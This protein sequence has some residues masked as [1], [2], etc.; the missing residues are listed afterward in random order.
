MPFGE[1]GLDSRAALTVGKH[2]LECAGASRRRRR[3]M[4]FI[5]GLRV[6]GIV[7]CYDLGDD[8][9][10]EV[11]EGEGRSWGTGRV[12]RKDGPHFHGSS[13][14]TSHEPEAG[15]VVGVVVP[16]KLEWLAG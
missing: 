15:L 3:E 5:G 1:I 8:A 10:A 14:D 7:E 11:L 2:H 12:G 4:G 13:T 9:V 6:A 16:V